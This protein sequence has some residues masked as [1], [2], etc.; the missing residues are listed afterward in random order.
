MS[1][2]NIEENENIV[3]KD[4]DESCLKQ[5]LEETKVV[6]PTEAK[7]GIYVFDI[8]YEPE[9]ITNDEVEACG[10]C[11]LDFQKMKIATKFHLHKIKSTILHENIHVIDDQASLNLTEKQIRALGN[12][13]FSW[14]R[15]NPDIVEYLMFDREPLEPTD[16]KEDLPI[17]REE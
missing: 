12:L 17:K 16:R 7:F 4:Q 15:E 1:N 9:V 10:T 5:H 6:R 2:E 3:V 14:M 11:S 13:M 8:G